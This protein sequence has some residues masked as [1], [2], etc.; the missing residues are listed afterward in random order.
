MG[1]LRKHGPLERNRPV[2]TKEDRPNPS[3]RVVWGLLAPPPP[4]L[5]E[6]N[7]SISARRIS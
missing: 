7:S 5:Y 1:G 2:P 3:Y 6:A 4:V